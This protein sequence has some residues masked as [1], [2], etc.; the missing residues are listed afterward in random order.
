MQH[1]R[2]HCNQS[3][4]R[5]ACSQAGTNNDRHAPASRSSFVLCTYPPP[6]YPPPTSH[7]PPPIAHLSSP[8]SHRPPPSA[9]FG[10]HLTAHRPTFLLHI[11]SASSSRQAG[12]SEPFGSSSDIAQCPAAAGRHIRQLRCFLHHLVPS[13]RFDLHIHAI[14]PLHAKPLSRLITLIRLLRHIRTLNG[15]N[16]STLEHPNC[17]P[18]AL[19]PTSPRSRVSTQTSKPTIS[20]M[21]LLIVQ[22][23]LRP[24]HQAAPSCLA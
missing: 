10:S 21:C 2:L 1:F 18:T 12:M 8:T 9:I 20:P 14:S 23:F 16:S 7:R 5:D 4:E 22:D 15:S 11:I 6:T 17:P 24:D 3:V 19:Y 13:S